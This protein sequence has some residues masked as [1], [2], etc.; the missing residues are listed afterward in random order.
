MR[1]LRFVFMLPNRVILLGRQLRRHVREV[2]AYSLSAKASTHRA[3][4]RTELPGQT[5]N[6]RS[7][8]TSRQRFT[9]ETYRGSD[10]GPALFEDLNALPSPHQSH[11]AS[12]FFRSL[13]KYPSYRRALT[14]LSW[15]AGV[16]AYTLKSNH[17]RRGWCGVP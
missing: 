14:W 13:V 3:D 11:P 8:G 1:I 15:G 12:V 9:P 2:G 7:V 4:S 5:V 16:M 17:T 6:L 10:L